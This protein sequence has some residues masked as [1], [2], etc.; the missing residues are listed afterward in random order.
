M[1]QGITIIE[2]AP[3]D[4]LNRSYLHCDRT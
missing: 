3:Y 4:T 1:V 2:E